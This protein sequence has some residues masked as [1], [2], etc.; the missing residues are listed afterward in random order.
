VCGIAGY[1]SDQQSDA[2]LLH[3]M[4]GVLRHRGPDDEGYYMDGPIQM[5][6]RRLSIIDV[7]SGHQPMRNEDGSVVV[8]FNGEIYNFQELR[9]ALERRGHR[10]RT[11]SDTECIVHLYEDIGE[12]CVE[13][14]RG[15]F[16]FAVWDRRR[17]NLFLARDRVGKKPLYYR[18]L[19]GGIAFASEL[20]ALLQDPSFPRDLDPVALDHYLTYQYIP[21]PLSIFAE[22]RKLPPAHTLTFSFSENKVRLHRYWQL[23]YEPKLSCSESEAAE[24]VREAVREATRVRLVAERPVGAF[25]SGGLDSSLVVACMAEQTS[26]VRTFSIGFDE[27]AWDERYWARVVAEHL[28]TE[29]CEM[30]VRPDIEAI[31]PS[32]VWHYDEPFADSSAIPSWY[33]AEMTRRN[34]TVALNGDGG[35]ESFA[36]YD[37]Y[38]AASAI[39]SMPAGKAVRAVATSL[40]SGLPK[41]GETYSRYGRGRR[42]I[43]LAAAD[44]A[45][46]YGEVVSCFHD[47]E[48]EALYLPDWRSVL[49][50]ADPYATL[51]VAARSGGAE[52]GV[53]RLLSTDVHTYLPGDL[54]VKVDIA[55]MA[56][57]LEARSPLLDH[58]LM[59]L[60]A[61]L[62]TGMKL[63]RLRGKFILKEAAR[64]LVPD[65]VIHRRKHG[66]G[67]PIAS[68]LR[69]D[70]KAMTHDVL[71]DRTFRSRGYF[72]A[73]YVER[74]LREHMAGRP[75]G[76]RIW[77][78][79]QFELWAR[80]FVDGNATA[81]PVAN[82]RT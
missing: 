81:A 73:K 25:L 79:L 65:E 43:E 4:C 26:H 35:D 41:R 33:L 2:E 19:P 64:G 76:S 47:R 69:G 9:A 82:V 66:F 70:L 13:H 58:H 14:L 8:V 27:A 23:R 75:H 7:T 5:G 67:V 29:H 30:V 59:E 6:M 44:P 3:R 46:R 52:K 40:H 60:A 31:L 39:D 18:L 1:L 80:T 17:Q 68:W 51:E 50:G 61:R 22:A 11:A 45:R 77:A 15:M 63:K 57:S 38:R 20:K 24:L 10:F 72:D 37:R 56:H 16:A 32:L 78:L 34:V 62:P 71:T 55:T 36:G 21:A 12:R 48:R 53:D 54:L 28:G 49:G 74:L 42:A